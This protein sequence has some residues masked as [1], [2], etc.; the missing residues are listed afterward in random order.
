MEKSLQ[1]L[2]HCLWCDYSAL[3]KQADVIHRALEERGESV[4]ND[5][6]AFRTFDHP[7]TSIEILAA[8]FLKR[9]YQF[10]GEPYH[11]NEKKLI[12]R[13]LEHFDS[14][15]PKIFISALKVK[16]LSK[17]TQ[18]IIGD[19]IKQLPKNFG[20]NEDCLTMG[21]PWKAVSFSAYQ[22]LLDE[23]EY[24]AWMSVFGFRVNHFTVFVNDLKSFKKLEDLNAFVKKDLGFLL[25]QAGGEI[26]GSPQL[27]LE[28]SSTRAYTVEVSFSDKKA[29]IPSC[30]YEFAQRYLLPNGELFQAFLPDSADKIF[31]ST[32]VHKTK[33]H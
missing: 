22:D 17:Q 6:V 26:K 12:A 11:F 3:N 29:K 32:N 13:H 8:P 2:L 1:E 20:Q 19:L 31:E 16:E 24:A 21:A 30:Y 27:Y 7:K 28:Q 10:K 33:L 14:R 5:H 23:S 4:V 18:E 9:G 15:Q 25:N